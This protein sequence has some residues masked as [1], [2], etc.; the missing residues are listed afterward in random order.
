MRRA[1][2]SLCFVVFVAFFALAHGNGRQIIGDD[3]EWLDGRSTFYDGIDQGACS[4]GT[5]PSQMFPYRL[6]AG[7]CVSL[8][9]KI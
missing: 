9:A 2:A 7:K 3:S 5:I 1:L 6:I 4:F 8:K